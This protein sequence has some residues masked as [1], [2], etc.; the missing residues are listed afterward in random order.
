MERIGRVPLAGGKGIFLN[1]VVDE[2]SMGMV[3]EKYL[4]EK[5]IRWYGEEVLLLRKCEKILNRR[6]SDILTNR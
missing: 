1:M 4:T 6:W 2:L 5:W 3:S